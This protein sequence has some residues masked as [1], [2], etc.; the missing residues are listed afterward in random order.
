MI[1]RPE[2][3]PDFQAFFER[4]PDLYLVLTRDLRIVAASDAYCGATLTKRED[5]LGRGIFDAF[6]DNPADANA[7]GVSNLSAS[8]ARVVQS[9]RPDAMP[10]QKYDIPRPASEGGGFEERFWRPLNTPLL[11][12]DGN[13]VWIIHRVEDVTELARMRADE[14]ASNRLHD[15]QRGMIER[16][17]E[18]NN[19]LAARNEENVRLQREVLSGTADLQREVADRRRTD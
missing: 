12:G 3:N 8:L 14:E 2:N 19:Q 9:G 17:S 16:L 10:I 11:D 15:Q 7:D 5:L 1:N 4:A 6:P 18:S 13:V